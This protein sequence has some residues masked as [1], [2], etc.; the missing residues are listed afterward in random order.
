MEVKKIGIPKAIADVTSAAPAATESAIHD[1]SQRDIRIYSQYFR[2]YELL[3]EY[4]NLRNPDHCPHGMYIM[5][6]ADNLNEWWG[7]LLLH[8]GYYKEGV[9]K[10]HIQIPEDY[11]SEGP[12]VRFTT[13][14]FHPLVDRSGFFNMRQQFPAWRANKD[15]ICHLLHYIKNSFKEAVLAN[16]EESNCPNR[17]AYNMFMFERPL[18]AKLASQCA[19]LSASDGILFS[20]DLE[21]DESIIKFRQLDDVEFE[22]LKAEML[23]SVNVESVDRAIMAH[24]SG[25]QKNDLLRDIKSVTGNISRMLSTG[26]MKEALSYYAKQG[27]R[28]EV[29]AE[30]SSVGEGGMHSHPHSQAA[31]SDGATGLGG[32]SG[33]N[34]GGLTGQ[35]KPL[36][37]MIAT[38]FRVSGGTTD[39]DPDDA[40]DF[41]YAPANNVNCG[42]NSSN[43]DTDFDPN[44]T[45]AA[46]LNSYPPT[47]SAASNPPPVRLPLAVRLSTAASTNN[48]NQSNA[49][50]LRKKLHKHRHSNQPHYLTESPSS[51][52]PGHIHLSAS[53]SS[54]TS[55]MSVGAD[56][57]Q[58]NDKKRSAALQ[59]NQQL[60][61]P[62]YTHYNAAGS[63]SPVSPPTSSYY[64]KPVLQKRFRGGNSSSS[65]RSA[66]D[67]ASGACIN[68]S[69][70]KGHGVVTS[71]NLQDHEYFKA[72]SINGG[73]NGGH[74]LY[75]RHTSGGVPVNERT[76]L[77]SGT[78]KKKSSATGLATGNLEIDAGGGVTVSVSVS[79]D[80][81][82]TSVGRP[83][84]IHRVSTVLRRLTIWSF[85]S[86]LITCVF[87]ALT[88]MVTLTT[89]L[90]PVAPSNGNRTHPA[91]I[92]PT[93]TW[94]PHVTRVSNATAKL[95]AFE[96]ELM[97]VNWGLVWNAVVA[98]ADLEVFVEASG[99]IPEP[100]DGGGSHRRSSGEGSLVLSG[101]GG[102]R[103]GDVGQGQRGNS[104]ASRELLAHVTVLDVPAVFGPHSI[105][106]NATA[107]I[108]IDQPKSTV[109]KIIYMNYP[110]QLLLTGSVRYVTA[111]G[112]FA[113]S[114]PVCSTHLV[115][116]PR[117][118]RSKSCELSPAQSAL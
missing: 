105:T 115:L 53:F 117:D 32:L 113:R 91:W 13:D 111:F 41:V 68:G 65:A 106:L 25:N 28:L 103:V 33:A 61:H 44:D 51:Q 118:V 99:V 92:L 64:S 63:A 40:E 7:V 18:F 84:S 20:N 108:A 12:I 62:H 75:V 110:Y 50:R 73:S 85:C 114:I 16:L 23:Q 87:I 96:F 101:D 11:P 58:A 116:S 19:Q 86:T 10:F 100:D 27:D 83:L 90:T 5:P 112:M 102:Q 70:F 57:L 8:R 15:F 77:L 74:N 4:K 26:L 35:T 66:S 31:G 56:Y 97:A 98:S 45:P 22:K 46:T 6:E 52:S 69:Y 109:G 107:R 3:I 81:A 59:Q 49:T 93:E 94:H 38:A 30:K 78:L 80:T 34:G 24:S 43:P 2:R 55:S 88:L 37:S 71:T 29:E 60:L 95:Y 39:Y 1:Q 9:F 72:K 47:D 21:E 89:P 79:D 14:M 82:I 104:L 17:D 42:V 76:H 36:R 54:S 48:S 67:A